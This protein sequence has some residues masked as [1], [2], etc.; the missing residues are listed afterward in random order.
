MRIIH[1]NILQL[2]FLMFAISIC[3]S[4]SLRLFYYCRT[5]IAELKKIQQAGGRTKF[6][7]QKQPTDIYVTGFGFA[8]AAYGIV[9]LIQGHYRLATGKGKMD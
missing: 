9:Q 4:L 1:E 5:Q 3:Y 7:W 8:L 6:T 2:S